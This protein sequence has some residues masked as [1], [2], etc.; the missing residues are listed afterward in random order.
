MFYID[1]LSS[2]PIYE[3][4]IE[5]V[6]RQILMQVLQ[7]ND[8]LPSVRSLAQ[9]LSVNPNT[10]QKAYQELIRREICYSVPGV[11]RKVSPQA[12]IIVRQRTQDKMKELE[13]LVKELALA[14]CECETVCSKIKEI[15]QTLYE[16]EALGYAFD[17]EKEGD[18]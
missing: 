2:V 14:G 18:E 1:K 4:L 7:P 10:L 5:Q 8:L 16:L 6:E 13:E 9:T 3:Q 15:Y 12:L 17:S 11:G